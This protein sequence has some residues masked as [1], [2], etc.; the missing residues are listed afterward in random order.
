MLYYGK[1]ELPAQFC[2]GS[3]ELQCFL[4]GKFI[5]SDAQP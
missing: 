2:S 5:F 4:L 1:Q 3:D